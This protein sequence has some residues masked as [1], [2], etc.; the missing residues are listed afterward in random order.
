MS[1]GVSSQS[2]REFVSRSLLVIV[3]T[4]SALSGIQKDVSQA[5]TYLHLP[6][7]RRQPSCTEAKAERSSALQP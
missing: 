4:L 7:D 2:I 6:R 1:S 3:I 5:R